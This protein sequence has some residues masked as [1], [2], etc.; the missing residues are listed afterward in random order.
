MQYHTDD[1]IIVGSDMKDEL[2]NHAAFEM[3]VL[4]YEITRA[5]YLA[6]DE[7]TLRMEA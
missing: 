7:Y 3:I 6:T 1:R 2:S 4:A 5:F